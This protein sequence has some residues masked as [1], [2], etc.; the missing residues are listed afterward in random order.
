M[1]PLNHLSN[2][3]T[4]AKLLNGNFFKKFNEN[5]VKTMLSLPSTISG[6]KANR[7]LN[8]QNLWF[9]SKQLATLNEGPNYNP[10]I[11]IKVKN[12]IDLLS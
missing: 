10:G 9:F 11:S 6:S 8:E 2:A 3:P 7:F 12:Q 5:N 1:E 4:H